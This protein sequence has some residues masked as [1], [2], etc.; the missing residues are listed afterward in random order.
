MCEDGEQKA[1]KSP[2]T[3]IHLPQGTCHGL[4]PAQQ[5]KLEGLTQARTPPPH[6]PLNKAL[7]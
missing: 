3:F 4:M 2:G 6:L 5:G 1:A 7:R